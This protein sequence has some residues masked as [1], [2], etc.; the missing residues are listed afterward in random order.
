MSAQ[1]VGAAQEELASPAASFASGGRAQLSTAGALVHR[2]AAYGVDHVFGI[3]G[4]HSLPIY[5]ELVAQP[6]LR[7]VTP[8]HEQGGGFAADGYARVTGRPAVCLTTSGPGVINAATAVAVAY[9]DSVPMLLLSPS[10][11]T[12][13]ES[14]STGYTHEAKDQ[15]GAL[16]ALAERSEWVRSPH[17]AVSAVDRAMIGYAVGRRRPVHWNVPLDAF[18][19]EAPVPDELPA[20]PQPCLPDPN[21]IDRVAALLDGADRCTLVLGGGAADAGPEA[22]ELAR[23]LG[24]AVITTFNGKGVVSERDPHSMGSSIRLDAAHALLAE[25]DVVVA[26]GT[27]LGESD[28]WHEPPLALRGRL[29]RI[30]IDP[31]QIHQNALADIAVLSDARLALHAVLQALPVQSRRSADAFL[32]D[33]RRRIDDDGARDGAPF[34]R[35]VAAIEDALGDDG[36]LVNDSAMACYCGAAQYLRLTGSRRFLYPSGF[37]TLGYALPAAIGA[38]LGR[39]DARVVALMGDGGLLFTV[40]ELSTAAAEGLALPVIVHNNNSYGEIKRQMLEDGI[41]ALGVDLH[42][43]DIPSLASAFGIAGVRVT[44][45]GDLAQELSAAFDRDCPTLIEVR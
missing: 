41:P 15:R 32:A 10:M 36:V 34:Q 24:A 1:P 13:I 2:L 45:H 42:S 5:R 39:P 38:K 33:A 25:S 17:H 4:T 27:E 16:A 37:G 12:R 20:P 14:H 21:T 11:P 19:E 44:D 3:P 31:A 7:H 18:A 6:A 8:R 28:T 35:M 29:V 43:Y 23:R 26:V 22:T 40:G 9:A 30:D